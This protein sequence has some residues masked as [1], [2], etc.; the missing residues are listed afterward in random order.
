AEVHRRRA[1]TTPAN[2]QRERLNA[3]GK[4]APLP[5]AQLDLMPGDRCSIWCGPRGLACFRCSPKKRDIFMRQSLRT[6]HG[7]T[8]RK[9]ASQPAIA[10]LGLRR[11]EGWCDWIGGHM[12]KGIL[13]AAPG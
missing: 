5:Q 7:E 3:L 4:F 10:C 6:R 13:N 8:A 1:D 11:G 12:R 2:H 9:P